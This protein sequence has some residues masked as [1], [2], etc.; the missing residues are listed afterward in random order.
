MDAPLLAGP[1]HNSSRP[2]SALWWG[3]I[4][5]FPIRMSVVLTLVSSTLVAGIVAAVTGYFTQRALAARQA[6]ID[7]E[8]NAKK[9][10]Y[11]AVCPLRFQLMLPCRHVV[12]R[13]DVHRR[14]SRWDMSPQ[15]YYVH[16][17]IYRLLRPLAVS[18]L[19]ERQM[20]YADFSVDPQQVR[21]LRF[22]A[23]AYRMLTERDP[24][25]YHDGIDWAKESQHLFRE[26]LR[27]AALRLIQQDRA[28]RDIVMDYSE[29]KLTC[30]D[31]IADEAITPLAQLFSGARHALRELPQWWLRLVGYAWACRTLISEQGGSAGLDIPQLQVQVLLA[32][33]KDP[34]IEENLTHYP[35]IFVEVTSKGL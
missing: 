20:N 33:I 30:P 31:P 13:V 35:Q 32:S 24:M 3:V 21:L 15:G 22:S 10:L 2:T 4:L 18:I 6:R 1:D 8:Y 19:I 27:V 12:N 23:S 7:Y 34:L 9:R 26:N 11:E 17:F 5:R 16:S 29:F 14:S 28:G 25:P